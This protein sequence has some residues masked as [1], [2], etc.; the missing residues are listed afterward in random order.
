MR[1]S[2]L[3]FMALL[4]ACDDDSAKPAS[5]ADAG[6]LGEPDAAVDAG[7]P[8]AP[9]GGS[10]AGPALSERRT[11]V[12]STLRMPVSIPDSDAYGFDLDG[13]GMVDNRLG[14]AYAT[15][16]G[17]GG[18]DPQALADEAVARGEVIVLFEVNA[19]AFTPGAALEGRVLEG[20]SSTPAACSGD[21]DTVCGHHLD[22][23][24]SFVAVAPA[25]TAAPG[26]IEGTTLSFGPG[27][28][29]LPLLLTDTASW[30]GLER[31]HVSAELGDGKLSQGKLGGAIPAMEVMETV[32]PAIHLQLAAQV[33]RDCPAMMC[34]SGSSGETL[35]QLFDADH[36]A[37]LSLAE[38]Q[39]NAII[40]AAFASDVDLDGDGSADAL[41][42]GFGFEAVPAMFSSP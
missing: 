33:Q 16:A 28:G 9:D 22:G 37:A 24:A 31:F 15:L 20:G 30:A 10:D 2:L 5:L 21:S 27:I 4:G 7:S 25:P 12:A 11:W 39:D 35:L 36:D 38:L 29:E 23:H 41:S 17:S 34:V 13:D 1:R 14:Q 40:Q 8:P 32:I 6:A 3:L 42:A 18:F 19:Q 26:G